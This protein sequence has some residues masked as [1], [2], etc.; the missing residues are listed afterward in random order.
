[1]VDVNLL[2]REFLLSQAGVTNLLGT[3][4]NNSIYC[5]YDLPEHF[6]PSLG[7]GIQIY[8]AGGKSHAE[9]TVLVDARVVVR[10][11]T[12]VEEA[13]LASQ[14]YSAINDALHGATQVSLPDGT[15]VRSLEVTGPQEGTDPE[16]GWVTVHA[17]Y[18]VMARPNKNTP[19]IV[20]LEGALDG[21]APYS[22]SIEGSN[23]GWFPDGAFNQVEGALDGFSPYSISIEGSYDGGL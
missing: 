23:S 3:N 9:I 19:A 6:D 18:A 16:T 12:D 10:V 11:W 8:R 17:F 20:Y 7:P 14:V 22:I 5:G 13:L 4:A 15:I 1:V 21:G 2:V